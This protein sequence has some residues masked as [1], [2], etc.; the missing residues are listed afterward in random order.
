MSEADPW[1]LKLSKHPSCQ[2]GDPASF[3]N[4]LLKALEKMDIDYELLQDYH[5]KEGDWHKA[6]SVYIKF[7]QFDIPEEEDVLDYLG[8]IIYKIG[9]VVGFDPDT[10]PYLD[11]L[12][13]EW[14]F[15]IPGWPLGDSIVHYKYVGGRT[16]SLQ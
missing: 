16:I 5:Y 2:H 8:D 4:V 13:D 6:V 12:T 1:L 10:C 7:D 14:V 15:V 3:L 11:E 9:R